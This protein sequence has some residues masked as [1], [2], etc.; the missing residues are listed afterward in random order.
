MKLLILL[1]VLL[2]TSC[3]CSFFKLPRLFYFKDEVDPNSLEGRYVEFLRKN[4]LNNLIHTIN[5][6]ADEVVDLDGDVDKGDFLA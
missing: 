1:K 3:I 2:D 4:K 6:T 5:P